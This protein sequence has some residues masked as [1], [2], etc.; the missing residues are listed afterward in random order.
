MHRSRA[1]VAA[2]LGVSLL[3]AA[4]GGDDAEGAGG[5][6]RLDQ[7]VKEGVASQ[8]GETAQKAGAAATDRAREIARLA[9]EKMKEAGAKLKKLSDR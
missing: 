4:C 8:L 5:E 9:G 7:A 3:A 1:L 6:A 2:V